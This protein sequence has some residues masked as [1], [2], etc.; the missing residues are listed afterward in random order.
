MS[1]NSLTVHDVVM[2]NVECFLNVHSQVIVFVSI[3]IARLL[4]I[5]VRVFLVGAYAVIQLTQQKL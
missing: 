2:N 4:P 5:L 1:L 3:R